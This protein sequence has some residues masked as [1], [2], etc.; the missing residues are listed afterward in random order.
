MELGF[1][2]TKGLL[3]SE[4]LKTIPQKS[5]NLLQPIFEAIMNSFEAIE[6][7]NRGKI[8]IEFNIHKDL[9]T[10]K[11]GK[12]QTEK[13]YFK[14]ITISDNGIGFNEK[15]FYRFYTLRDNSK[16]KNNKGTGPVLKIV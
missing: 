16:N 13:C 4:E 5:K 3:L 11:D 15:E 7:L 9:F 6:I 8:S 2:E 14:N 10:E 1:H 12:T